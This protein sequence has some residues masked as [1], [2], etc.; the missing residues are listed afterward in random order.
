[1]SFGKVLSIVAELAKVVAIALERRI[2]G[3]VGVFLKNAE[4]LN[5]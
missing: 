5:K 1:M 3:C 4:V 2:K